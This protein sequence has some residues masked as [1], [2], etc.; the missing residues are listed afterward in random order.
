MHQFTNKL[1]TETSPYL[2]QHAHNP[3]NWFPWGDEA[4][5]KA[6]KENKPILVSIGYS[7]CHWCH[8]MERESFEDEETARIMNEHFINIKIDREERPDLDHIYMDAVQAMTGS[9]GWPLNVFLTPG[10]KPFY[11]G[12]YFPPKR[13]FNRP[14][15]QEVLL[16]VTEA[17]T[18]RRNEIDAQAENLTEHLVQSNAFGISSSENNFFSKEKIYVAFENIMKNADK[19]WGG[20]GKAPKFPQSF[21]LQWLLRFFYVTENKEALDQALLSIDRMIDGGIYDQIG[22]GFAR[23]STDTEW[24][25]PHFEKMLY[26]N[27]LLVSVISESYQITGDK[28]YKEV[29]EETI[30]FLQ[31]ELMH[32]E[33]GFYAALDADSE[34]EEGKFYVWNYEEVKVFL[35]DDASIFCDFF[36]IKPAGNWEEK[37]ILWR[38]KRE[39]IF[40]SEKNISLDELERIIQKGKKILL[41]KRN[42]RIRPQTDTKILL[43][44]NALMNT[45]LCKAFAATG[46]ESFKQLAVDN[47]QFLLS[48][49]SK[50]NT[51]EYFH[52]W[53]NNIA[54]Q[55]AFLD[56]YAFLI[57]ALIQ[58]QEV[59][60]NTD[61]LEKAKMVAEHLVQNF[62]DPA[63]DFFFYT[64][65]SQKDVVVRKK[66]VHDGAQPS[67]NSITADNLYRLALYFDKSDWK[68]KSVRMINS[69]GNA[70]VRYP[71]SFGSWACLLMEN[72]FGTNEIAII[73]N[74]S[75]HILTQVLNEY[76]PHKIIMSA[77]DGSNSF[78]LLSGKERSNETALYLCR[79]Y[80]C[81]NPVSSIS[82]L[83]DLIRRKELKIS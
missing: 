3:V 45:A 47:M 58:L 79:N 32:P 64:N 34:W 63:T 49:F 73:S 59:T 42:E 16:G 1:I 37:N 71:T 57:Q 53:K 25:V 22:G 80:T 54:K 12:T 18:Q 15:W 6:K 68:E 46:N 26:D 83:I 74:E 30:E 23:Y 55:P 67:G 5:D 66:E 51:A 8:V 50:N 20:F 10:A 82:A 14:S 69:L 27:A 19:E 28:R 56:D 36:D 62:N 61:Y 41:G 78:P 72:T 65:T 17:F 13:A 48:K 7:A 9:G 76:I 24:L 21:V 33:G 70:I 38:K 40:S 35:N 52:S 39:E 11:G 75:Q 77:K 43:G 60:G 44:W 81:E 29:I 4:L 2:L 31:R